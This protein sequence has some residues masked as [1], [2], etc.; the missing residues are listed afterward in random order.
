VRRD[1]FA[2][3]AASAQPVIGTNFE[4]EAAAAARQRRLRNWTAVRE[5]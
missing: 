2:P 5:A 1:L 4:G 3:I